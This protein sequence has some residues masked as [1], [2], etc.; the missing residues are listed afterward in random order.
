MKLEHVAFNVKDPVAV[1]AW[2]NRH[3]GLVTVRQL[4]V[5]SH[6]HFLADDGGTVLLE[7]Y[8]N[9]PDAVPPYA[10]M[11]PLLFHLAFVSDDPER[12]KAALLSAGATLVSDQRLADG[13]RLVMLRDPWGVALQL[14]K[15]A[16]PML[17]SVANAQ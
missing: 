11:D 14:C 10:D 1:A 3:L 6:T 8:N 13:S 16:V 7:I 15:R 9:P 4:A 2:Y 12:D 5:S 17:R